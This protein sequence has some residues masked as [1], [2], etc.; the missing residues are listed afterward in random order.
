MKLPVRGDGVARPVALI[1]FIPPSLHFQTSRKKLRR[2]W[3]AKEKTTMNDMYGDGSDH[4]VC[5]LCGFCAEC[6]DC[7]NFGCGKEVYKMPFEEQQ[8]IKLNHLVE[9]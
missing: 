5:D 4:E 9:K 2:G 7:E 1:G 3:M 8:K 6:S